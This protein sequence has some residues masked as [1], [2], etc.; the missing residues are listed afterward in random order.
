L[1]HL[2]DFSG[3][4]GI[5]IG[6]FEKRVAIEKDRLRKI[7]QTKKELE[8]IPVISGADFGHTTPIFTF[9]IGGKARLLAREGNIKLE[10]IEG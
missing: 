10:I 3:V 1:I 4:Q 8:K 2:P 6:R 9:P 5:V 7:I